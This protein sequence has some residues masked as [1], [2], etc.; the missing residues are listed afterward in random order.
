MTSDFINWDSL[1]NDKSILFPSGFK[2]HIFDISKVTNMTEMF[3]YMYN[4][5]GYAR[6]QEDADRFNALTGSGGINF[7][8]KVT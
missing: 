5:I 1:P 4:K 2:D 6:T 8:V 7:A 3:S